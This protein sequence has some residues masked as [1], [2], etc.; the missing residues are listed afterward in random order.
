M[1]MPALT[2]AKQQGWITIAADG[3]KDAPGNKLCDHFWHIDLKDR[4][5]LTERAA[6]WM[7]EQSLHGVFTAGTDFSASVAWVAQKLGLPGIPYQTALNATDKIRMRQVLKEKGLNTPDFWELGMD[8]YWQDLIDQPSFPLVVKPVDNMGARGVRRVD[9]PK[10][11]GEA[12]DIARSLSR[13]SRALVEQ[14]LEGP[15]FSLD[16]LIYKGNIQLCG[17][18]DR[19]I[20]FPPYF[21][22]MGHSFPSEYS[23]EEQQSV[24][25]E[26]FKGIQALGLN[27]G[28]AKGDIKL[29]PQGPVIGEIAARLSG[30]YMSGWTYPYA[31][32]KKPLLGA[33]KIAM[34]MEPGY[35]EVLELQ[36]CSERAIISIPGK[37]KTILGLEQAHE[38]PGIKDIFLSRDEGDSVSF[39]KNNVEKVG[40]I[41]ALG[42]NAKM[43]ATTAA[44][45]IYIRLEAKKV[46]TAQ[47][48]QG[49]HEWPGLAFAQAPSF[50]SK[51]LD[52]TDLPI[53]LF[54]EDV[55]LPD[56][57]NYEQIDWMGRSLKKCL[58]SLKQEYSLEFTEKP[59]ELWD[60]YFWKSLF[61]G[62]ILGVR[63]LIDSLKA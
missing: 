47:F 4:V 38:M 55:A 42:D 3:K 26:F 14:Y 56:N 48:L 15:E 17:L 59:L 54:C 5:G 46:E 53:S 28:A 41:I 51:T 39:P 7:E 16:A 63:W 25:E 61:R 35:H 36:S 30:G 32:G 29:T 31:S 24:K 19:D 18:A 43:K 33:M 37:I 8:Q 49:W 44:A 52:F 12:I 27:I 40:N 21:I 62:G 2:I 45:S 11:L 58:D 1:Q 6:L 9:S 20:H 13:T 22:E 34:D 60:L 10:E 57:L 50:F 23:K